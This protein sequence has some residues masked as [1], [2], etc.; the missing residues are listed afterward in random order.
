MHRLV[1]KSLEVASL[2]G[3][4]DRCGA[5]RKMAS[6][7]RNTLQT[8]PTPARQ[9]QAS[10][11]GTAQTPARSNATNKTAVTIAQVDNVFEYLRDY[12]VLV[13]KEQGYAV[14]SLDDH[15]KRQHRT[16]VGER[17]AIVARFAH[18]PISQPA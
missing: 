13:C 9:L 3:V 1:P 18:C 15:L 5:G 2:E 16:T 4:V 12:G 6:S 14:R 11:I 17:K 8:L 7:R 10:G